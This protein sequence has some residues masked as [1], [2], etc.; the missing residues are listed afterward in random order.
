MYGN[1]FS[2]MSMEVG[3]EIHITRDS[4]YDPYESYLLVASR[5]F[6]GPIFMGILSGGNNGEYLRGVKLFP[7]VSDANNSIKIKDSTNTT[8]LILS[9]TYGMVLYNFIPCNINANSK[10]KIEL[11]KKL[12]I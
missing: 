6:Q 10:F 5:D 7:I 8:P 4:I 11:V 2:V 3:D 9:S 1:Y 12:K